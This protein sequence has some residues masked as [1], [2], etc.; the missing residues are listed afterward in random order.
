[1]RLQRSLRLSGLVLLAGQAGCAPGSAPIE[2]GPPAPVAAADSLRV[3]ADAL[4][5]SCRVPAL[6]VAVARRG[7]VLLAYARGRANVERGV[8]ASIHTMYRIGSVS[9]LLTAAAAM[10]LAQQG[11]LDLDAEIHR[12][13]PEFPV[14]RYPFT[15]RQLAGHLAG[16]RHYGPGE[17][18]NR[19]RYDSV[20]PSLAGF[21]QDSLLFPPGARYGYSSYGYNLLSLAI[22]RA[23]GAPFLRVV[24]REVLSPLRLGETA[25]DRPDSMIAMRAAPY[26]MLDGTIGPATPDDLSNRWASGGFLASVMDLVRFGSAFLTP[27]FL[28]ESVLRVMTTPQR[29]ASGEAAPVGIGW[30]IGRD[31]AGRLIWHHTG[32]SVG[33]R[34]VLVI[35][36]EEGLVVAIAGN[37]LFPLSERSA[38]RFAELARIPE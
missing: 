4:A 37:L 36:P 38:F 1:M 33:G 2:T 12:Y 9:K 14:K 10:R 15:L 11:R 31:A 6:S 29:L 7:R 20:A 3:L 26:D 28:A 25:P 17:F 18:V 13:V 23:A 19:V 34:A 5:D 24:E 8:P 35:W 30:R 16:I 21:R 32:S 27:G 22:E